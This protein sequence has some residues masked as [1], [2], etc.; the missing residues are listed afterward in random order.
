MERMDKLLAEGDRD[1]VVEA[2]FRSVEELSDGVW[3]RSGRRLPGQDGSPP[4]TQ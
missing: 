2:L 1:S 4:H 3:P